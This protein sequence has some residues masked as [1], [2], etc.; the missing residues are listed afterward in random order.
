[1]KNGKFLLFS[2]IGI[3]IAGGL[4]SCAKDDVP[5]IAG[6]DAAG[7][8][9]TIPTID[10]M[11][12]TS[13][14]KT[15]IYTGNYN[16]EGQAL[17]SRMKNTTGTLTD[18]VKTII[19]DGNKVADLAHNDYLA[20]LRTFIGGANLVVTRPTLTEFIQLLVNLD[21]VSDELDSTITTTGKLVV[22]P[23]SMKA[24][25]CIKSKA[26][27]MK[28]TSRTTPSNPIYSDGT[29]DPD[30]DLCEM[31]AL[32]MDDAYIMDIV[33]KEQVSVQKVP[34]TK[35]DEN[36]NVIS[37]DSVDITVKHTLNAYDYGKY[38]DEATSWLNELTEAAANN[39]KEIS[40]GREIA[41]R[42]D[43]NIDDVRKNQ[44]A[45][46]ITITTT[47]NPPFY[48]GS[49]VASTDYSIWAF[50][51]FSTGDDVYAVCSET[52]LPAGDL[53]HGI[54]SQYGEEQTIKF[55]KTT[56]F[57][58]GALTT[59]RLY[60]PYLRRMEIS[61]ELQADGS[62]VNLQEYSPH[63][64]I[65]T[66]NY[67]CGTSFTL[68]GGLTALGPQVTPSL[69][70]SNNRSYNL[71]DLNPY[72]QTSGAT[73]S[74]KFEGNISKNDYSGSYKISI[75]TCKP[76]LRTSS[77]LPTVAV[78]R[79]KNPK[80]A[81]CKL[82]V[83]GNI[84]IGSMKMKA[85]SYIVWIYTFAEE[86]N[87]LNLIDTKYLDLTFPAHYLFNWKMSV[88]SD[89]KEHKESL[90]TFLIK[91]Y[92]KYYAVLKQ[93]PE[94]YLDSAHKDSINA[95]P[96]AKAQWEEFI[97]NLEVD[98]QLGTLKDQSIPAGKYVINMAGESENPT[99]FSYILIVK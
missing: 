49:V 35:F 79:V 96:N 89:T 40:M 19:L 44:D 37:R 5:A 72:D 98:N 87:F 23:E 41:S 57:E 48:E 71:L 17:I 8:S 54:M 4:Y 80:D 53:A 11:N 78:W 86:Y 74:C 67:Q 22:N 28:A 55:N 20:I 59:S 30:A 66:T 29:I 91:S 65:G 77:L 45:Q 27:S 32:N 43:I 31:M 63:T 92:P 39:A 10:S 64:G 76:I 62:T 73:Q 68:G 84:I 1:M 69:A 42:A 3:F 34:D 52:R 25:D 46:R 14:L 36:G 26:Q 21:E 85:V 16:E 82:K 94:R 93:Y 6:S 83:S 60:G 90:E 18:D 61:N 58:G 75:P 81:N 70:F 51:E 50:H 56:V 9:E 33:N 88:S 95:Y 97:K 24:L 47:V 99:K 2:L 15:Y 12:V 38:A 7:I 13:S